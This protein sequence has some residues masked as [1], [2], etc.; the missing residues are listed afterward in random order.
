MSEAALRRA[1]NSQNRVLSSGDR[2]EGNPARIVDVV[3]I[4]DDDSV[5]DVVQHA[6]SLRDYES[7]RFSDGAEAAR[8]LGEGHVKGRVVLLDVGL[9]SLDGFGVLRTLRS[10]GVLDDTRVIMLT[11]RSSEAEMLLALGLG[12]MEHI[13]KPFSI[14]ILLGRLGQTLSRSAA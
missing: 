14:P 7:V 4:E 5:A 13:T 12:A 8:A 6:L 9:P 10:Q 11:A 2:V 3:L 1:K